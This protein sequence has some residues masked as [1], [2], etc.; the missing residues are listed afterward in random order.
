MIIKQLGQGLCVDRERV[1]GNI[2]IIINI[3]SEWI[4]EI[5]IQNSNVFTFRNGFS[6]KM[7]NG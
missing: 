3:Q 2:I 5:I 6:Y 4:D 7:I 1:V